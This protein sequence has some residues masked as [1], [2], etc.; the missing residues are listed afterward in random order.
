MILCDYQYIWS[1]LGID[2]KDFEMIFNN[3]R[4]ANWVQISVDNILNY[5]HIFP[6]N[7]PWQYMQI[8]SCGDI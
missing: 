7:R 5:L 8:V 4:L 6:E 1:L 2:S 3:Q